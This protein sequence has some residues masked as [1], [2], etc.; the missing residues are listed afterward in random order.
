M[1]IYIETDKEE[2]LFEADEWQ[3][4]SNGILIIANKTKITGSA[5]NTIVAC[6]K[7]WKYVGGKPLDCYVQAR[8][9]EVLKQKEAD[10]IGKLKQIA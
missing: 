2:M 3:V 1:K 7:E 10:A 6:F 9:D 4:S 5:G 8:Y